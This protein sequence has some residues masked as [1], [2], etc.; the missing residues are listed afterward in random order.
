MPDLE[1]HAEH[2]LKRFGF[3]GEDI[4][5]FLDE[6]VRT[7]GFAHRE[8]RHDTETIKLVGRMFGSE[9]GR[10]LAENIALDH[11]MLDHEETIRKRKKDVQEISLGINFIPRSPQRN[12]RRLISFYWKHLPAI[13]FFAL[14]GTGLFF[15]LVLWIIQTIL[16]S[17]STSHL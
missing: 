2:T 1:H 9:Y 16:D 10:E 14:I 11:I 13:K 8:F 5:E 3:R 7:F 17:S 6:P 15:L 12:G 4:H